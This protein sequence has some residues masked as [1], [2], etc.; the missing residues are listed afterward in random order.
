M[1]RYFIMAICVGENSKKLG[2]ADLRCF[3][4]F[5]MPYILVVTISLILVKCVV[6]VQSIE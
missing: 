2:T 5:F 4:M 3:H 6:I 1:K